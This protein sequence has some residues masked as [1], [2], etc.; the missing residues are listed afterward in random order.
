MDIYHGLSETLIASG[1][2][3]PHERQVWRTGLGTDDITRKPTRQR[4]DQLRLR[5]RRAINYR[6]LLR[7]CTVAR[8]EATTEARRWGESNTRT[9]GKEQAICPVHPTSCSIAFATSR[10]LSKFHDPLYVSGCIATAVTFAFSL[11]GMCIHAA[12]P[13]AWRFGPTLRSVIA[14]GNNQIS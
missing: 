13:H 1:Q 9:V 5:L 14:R 4:R 7:R 8:G 6:A 2:F 3:A 10:E 11:L 12:I